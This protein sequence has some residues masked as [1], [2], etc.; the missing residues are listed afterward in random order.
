MKRFKNGCFVGKFLPPH[1]GHLSVIDRALSECEKV[2]VVLAEDL[3]HSKTLCEQANFPYFSPKERLEWIRQHYKNYNNINFIFFDEHG[4]KKDDLKTWSKKFK[5][6]VKGIDAKYADESYPLGNP[7]PAKSYLNIDKII[8]IALESG[9]D[10]IHPG[11]GFLAENEEFEIYLNKEIY[12]IDIASIINKAV[13]K[14]IKNGVEKD[15]N[16]FFIQNDENSIEIEIYLTE[17]EKTYKME[18]I[19]NQGTE[20]FVQFFLDAK[21]K[22]SKVE[23]NEK[24]GRI[25]YILFEQ[26]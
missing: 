22:S 19:Y 17:G 6:K 24:N 11:Y 13:D 23:Y 3:K 20:Q 14:N 9:A 8:D 12:G 15:E 25:K 26:I 21:F 1:I 4:I 5:E 18:Q 7:S 10:A 16:N 2:T